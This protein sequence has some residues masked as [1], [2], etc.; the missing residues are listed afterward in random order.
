MSDDVYVKLAEYLDSA[1]VGAP[2][3]DN[4]LEILKVLYTP[5]EAVLAVKI[6]F[7]NTDLP[8]LVAVSG[9]KEEKLKKLLIGM[10]KKGT[11]FMSDKGKFR[12]L[13]TMVGFAETEFW[14]GKQTPEMERLGRLWD[15]Y[16]DEAFGKEVSGRETPL[17][18]VVPVD[19]SLEPGAV[20]TPHEQ[21]DSLMDQLDYFAVGHCACRQIARFS[22]RDQCDHGTENCFHFGS[23]AKYSVTQGMARE[24]TRDEAKQLI[25]GVHEQGLVHIASNHGGRISTMCSCCSDCCVW[26]RSM[27]ELDLTDSIAKSNYVMRSD[28]ELCTACGTC[29]ERC[30][31]EAITVDDVADVDGD[32]CIGCGI[33]YPTCPSGAIRLVERGE[34][35]EIMDIQEFIQKLIQ[36]KG[37]I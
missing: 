23:M 24:I 30:P 14:P 6:P 25:R 1:P 9:Y 36:G 34:R 28:P 7:L 22:G 12:I 17:M 11:V 37:L 15:K 10:V 4:L 13:P 8:T 16:I 26:M 33:C 3:T 31:M 29:K 35:K 2:L 32:K 5:E 27:K 20:V 19:E 18:R 21:V